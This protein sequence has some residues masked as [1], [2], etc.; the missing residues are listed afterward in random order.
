[1]TEKIND[2]KYILKTHYFKFI[3][4]HNSNIINTY[5]TLYNLKHKIIYPD[6]SSNK[7]IAFLVKEIKKG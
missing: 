7:Q 5:K 4:K 6:S 2:N 1:M 3:D